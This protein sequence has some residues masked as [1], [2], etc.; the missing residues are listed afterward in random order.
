[1]RNGAA[2]RLRAPGS[3]AAGEQCSDRRLDCRVAEPAATSVAP[4]VSCPERKGWF[5]MTNR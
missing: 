5:R 3:V 4:P 2:A 1:M